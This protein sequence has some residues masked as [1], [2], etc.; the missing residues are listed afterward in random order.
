MS[1]RWSGFRRLGF[2]PLSEAGTLIS[3]LVIVGGVLIFAELIDGVVEGDSTAK[4][5]EDHRWYELP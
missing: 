4:A 3:V 5:Q 1:L 2:L